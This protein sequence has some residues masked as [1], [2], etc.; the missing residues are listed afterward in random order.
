MNTQSPKEDHN[1]NIIWLT[2]K[3]AQTI[4]SLSKQKLYR[5]LADKKISSKVDKQYGARKGAR[6]WNRESIDLY[7]ESLGD[8]KEIQ[9]DPNYT[10]KPVEK[11]NYPVINYEMV[12][13]YEAIFVP[14]RRKK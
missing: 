8:G 9:G 12:P 3:R 6:Y 2:S 14:S 5:L 13:Q 11:F 10:Y 1:N 4:Y 7:F